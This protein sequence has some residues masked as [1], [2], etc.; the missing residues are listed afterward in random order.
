MAIL[1]LTNHDYRRLYCQPVSWQN[2]HPGPPQILHLA[3]SLSS[4]ALPK[5]PLQRLPLSRSEQCWLISAT[6]M[7]YFPHI[8]HTATG[9]LSLAISLAIEVRL[10]TFPPILRLRDPL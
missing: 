5:T 7:V 1:Y 9:G 8:E 4:M 2:G 10:H 6:E 3:H